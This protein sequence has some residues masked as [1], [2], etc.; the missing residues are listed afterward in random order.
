M[1]GVGRLGVFLGS[2]VMGREGRH[3]SSRREVALDGVL[4]LDAGDDSKQWI[5]SSRYEAVAMRRMKEVESHRASQGV[6][7]RQWYRWNRMEAVRVK[8]QG[9]GWIWRW[10]RK[11]RERGHSIY[12]RRREPEK[13]TE[14]ET[15]EKRAREEPGHGPKLWRL[16][17]LWDAVDDVDKQAKATRGQGRVAD[18][19]ALFG[20]R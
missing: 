18:P 13:A 10:M 6:K 19:W 12:Q 2:V 4:L 14:T 1:V 17:T 11:K 16:W 7:T 15:S 9:R 20:R 3:G 8:T 5:V